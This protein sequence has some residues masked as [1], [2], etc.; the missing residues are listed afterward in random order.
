MKVYLIG[1]GCG[2]E[3]LTREAAEALKKENRRFRRAFRK[4]GEEVLQIRTD[5]EKTMAG[6]LKAFGDENAGV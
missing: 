3:T 1:C 2:P 6:W 5:Y 4:A